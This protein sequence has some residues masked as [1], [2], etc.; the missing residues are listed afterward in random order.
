[1]SSVSDFGRYVEIRLA[2]GA[3]TQSLLRA[4]AERLRVRRFEI[5]EPS[6]HDIF[7]EWVTSH[8]AGK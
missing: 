6:L 7:V 1:V 2:D 4:C 8:G 5:V 3:D